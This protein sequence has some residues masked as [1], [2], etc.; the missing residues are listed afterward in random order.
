MTSSSTPADAAARKRQAIENLRRAAAP[1]SKP[2]EAPDGSA[3]LANADAIGAVHGWDRYQLVALKGEGSLGRVWVARD[4]RL[5]RELALKELKPDLLASGSARG[6]FLDEARLT[7]GL[8]HPFIVR[9]HDLHEADRPFYTMELVK[10]RTLQELIADYHALDV[11]DPAKP[12]AF[13]RLIGAFIQVCE[14]IDFA[15]RNG[16]I[17][18]DLKPANI[19]ADAQGEACILDWGLAKQWDSSTGNEAAVGSIIGTPAFMAPEQA[20]G[21]Q[22]RIDHRTDVFG[23]GA[24]L[25]AILTGR[26]PHAP[27]GSMDRATF[28]QQISDGAIAPPRQLNGLAPAALCA[29]CSKAMACDSQDR[30]Q[31]AGDLADDVRRWS[32]NEPTTAYREPISKRA[33]RWMVRH[34]AISFMASGAVIGLML[35]A[36]VV[37]AQTWAESN[38]LQTAL[39]ETV[40]ARVRATVDM[41]GHASDRPVEYLQYLSDL[42]DTRTLVASADRP[43][44]E[45]ASAQEQLREILVPFMRYRLH[46]VGMR[47]VKGTQIDRPLL[48][49]GRAFP[50]GALE[51]TA[52][53]NDAGLEEVVREAFK[54][55]EGGIY[56]SPILRTVWRRENSDASGLQIQFATPI[57]DAENRAA[58][59][60]AS[61]TVQFVPLFTNAR[62]ALGVEKAA[63]WGGS[64]Y[65]ASKAGDIVSQVDHNQELVFAEPSHQLTALFPELAPLLAPTGP[66]RDS[67]AV[68][69][70]QP[71]GDVVYATRLEFSHWQ[72]KRSIFIA[73]A[74]PATEFAHREREASM[75]AFGSASI[76]ILVSLAFIWI[77]AQFIIRVVNG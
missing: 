60:V 50:G 27:S 73:A 38:N 53:K 77:A 48:E 13:R 46:I 47:I 15:G 49:L 69:R 35:T 28:L 11:R 44:A 55:P 54:L 70:S 5:G 52:M 23:L 59:G 2:A 51:N 58:I 4:Q 65:V 74:I 3:K 42:P 61:M 71:S 64:V 14:G 32:H 1:T 75:I 36:V 10:G 25:Y 16:V 34:R 43:A 39:Q 22:R 21:D 33:A 19:M 6:R 62:E 17:H 9:V 76:I 68:S 41:I 37:L 40:R 67:M 31:R 45:L 18:R 24:I 26:P 56:L 20:V 8:E 72:P 66:V 30:Y 7:G 29:I 12:A 57:Y 63:T